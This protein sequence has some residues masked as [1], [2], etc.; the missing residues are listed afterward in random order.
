MSKKIDV[1][2]D[3][4]S[5]MRISGLTVQ[6]T[7]EDVEIAL[8]RLENMMA[9]LEGRNIGI[10]Y[11]FEEEPDPD[12]LTN[13]AREFWHMMATNL[14][15]RLL[16]DF[17]KV[18]P[19]SLI[20]QA[21]Q[22]LSNASGRVAASLLREVSYPSRQPIGSGNRRGYVRSNRYYS[23]VQEAPISADTN[24]VY[25]GDI[26]D[27]S[28]SFESYLN[29]GETIASYTIESDSLLSLSNDAISSD[30]IVYRVTVTESVSG[31]S[32]QR[33]KI[34]ATTSDG[35]KETRFVDFEILPTGVVG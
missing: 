29:S 15:I 6:P 3:A 27:Y 26:S 18:V 22:S 2:N 1:I 8:M 9:E 13:V 35:R 31:S 20:A 32:Y 16:A 21:G 33:V 34:V 14:S 17:N 23:D 5:Q 28:E 4:Y 7:P 11:S 25:P 24:K 10:G 30:L 12:T 19:Q